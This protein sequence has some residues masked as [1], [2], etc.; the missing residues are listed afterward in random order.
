MKRQ[1]RPSAPS[2][3]RRAVCRFAACPR[4][5]T[6]CC[7]RQSIFLHPAAPSSPAK[8]ST[9]LSLSRV[10]VA[11]QKSS[12]LQPTEVLLRQTQTRISLVGSFG[13]EIP[14]SQRPRRTDSLVDSLQQT[15]SV[16]EGLKHPDSS[17]PPNTPSLSSTGTHIPSSNLSTMHTPSAAPKRTCLSKLTRSSPRTSHRHRHSCL[18]QR[19]L[20][21]VRPSK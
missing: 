10:F 15:R 19:Q 20:Q 21:H 6:Y 14:L 12:A 11:G 16:A 13:I 1:H 3:T 5:R 2:Q 4:C 7:H 8:S 17:K 18:I 9:T